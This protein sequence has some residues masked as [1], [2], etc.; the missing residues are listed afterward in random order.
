MKYRTKIEGTKKLNRALARHSQRVTKKTKAALRAGAY[1]IENEATE[2]VPVLTGNLK[3]S[4]HTE[5][6]E[7]RNEIVADIGT[8]VDYA[9]AVEYGTK[10]RPAKPYLRPAFDRKAD[11]AEKEVIDTLDELLKKL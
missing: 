8:N 11:E 1:K 10:N 7:Q 6:E 9:E 5:V 4:I 2:L 3:R